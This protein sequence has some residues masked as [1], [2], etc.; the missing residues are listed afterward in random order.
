MK[1]SLP[2]FQQ[3]VNAHLAEAVI[4]N[5]ANPTMQW[6]IAGAAATGALLNSRVL[7]A[8]RMAGLVDEEGMVDVDKLETFSK[9]A[10]ASQPKVETP[11]AVTFEESDATAFLA[12]LRK[13]N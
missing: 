2:Q 11:F 1:V 8:M 9:A 3:A 12:R 4:P 5:I 10:F 13:L 7:S 6:F